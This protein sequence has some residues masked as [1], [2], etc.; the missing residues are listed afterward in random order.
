MIFFTAD[1]GGFYFYLYFHSFF[2]LQQVGLDVN[3]FHKWKL[4]F[5]VSCVLFLATALFHLCNRKLRTI[6]CIVI[7]YEYYYLSISSS[8]SSRDDVYT[9][10]HF[11]TL[12]VTS[13][14]L[15]LRKCYWCSNVEHICDVLHRRTKLLLLFLLKEKLEVPGGTFKFLMLNQNPR[16]T[17]RPWRRK[18]KRWT[19]IQFFARTDHERMLMLEKIKTQFWKFFGIF[20]QYPEHLG[21]GFVVSWKHIGFIVIAKN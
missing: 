9:C 14:F 21:L 16:S 13:T 3:Q 5:H 17:R 6:N 2:Y 8:L 18:R 7:Q 4:S 19:G 1:D 11:T 20:S 10:F 12:H 15:G